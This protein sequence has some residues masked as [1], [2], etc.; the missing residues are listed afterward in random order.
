MID[1][2]LVRTNTE[3]V[4]KN[5]ARRG[6]K[7]ASVTAL[8]ELD[9][10]WR[11][12]TLAL[13]NLRAEHNS[14]NEQIAKEL[15]PEER[16]SLIVAMKEKRTKE[17]QLQELVVTLGSQRDAAWRALPNIVA[18]DVPD[19][20]VDDYVIVHQPKIAGESK[21][22]DYFTLAEPRF[23][24]LERAA[25][26]SG[27]RFVYI[28][29]EVARLELALISYLFDTV[30]P[31]GFTPVIPPVLIGHTAMAGM[32]YLEQGADE[33]YQTQ[34]NLYLVGTSEQSIGPMHMNETLPAQQLPLRYVAF[35]PCFRREAG[36]HGKDVRGILRLHQ[37]DKVEM[38]SFTAPDQSAAEHEFLLEQQMKIMDALALPY[39]VIKL[40]A[41][42]LGAPASKTYDIETWIPSENK[43]RETHSTS[44][45]TD[46]QA[47]RLNI[48]VRDASGKTRKAHL[49]NGT[50]L[51]MSRALIAILENYQRA[52]GSI[53]IPTV[54]QPYLNFDHLSRAA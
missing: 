46:Y 52:D 51:A 33:I 1:I 41:K 24:D 34:D 31:L 36:S 25:K 50:A 45:T 40:A 43:F 7:P 49:L 27:S 8:L 39:R 19:G 6:V 42:D 17:K 14:A 26:V 16:E 29:G 15:A 54:L 32:G 2:D 47:R 53:G 18:D 10:E 9:E 12:V 35:S 38:F 4:I 3:A 44:N 22:L 37:F 20:G 48:R 30:S 11:R 21:P 28:K 5:L 13:E 23:I